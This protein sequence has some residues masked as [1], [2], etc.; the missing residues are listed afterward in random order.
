MTAP[1]SP[2]LPL[3]I[4][5]AIPAYWTP[6]QAQA[7]IE[8]LDDLRDRGS[9]RI[10]SCSSSICIESNR[11]SKISIHPILTTI[12]MPTTISRSEDRSFRTSQG[13]KP[14]PSFLTAEYRRH[15]YAD[16]RRR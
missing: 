13:A 14:A 7:V 11:A 4:P 16:L 15:F 1:S 2:G 9:A 3:T 6:D 8:L 10:T 5:L 12:S